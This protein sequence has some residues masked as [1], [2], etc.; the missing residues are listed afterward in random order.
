MKWFS[1]NDKKTEKNSKNVLT[2]REGFG[3][4]KKLSHE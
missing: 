1:K 3:N 2:K 4:I